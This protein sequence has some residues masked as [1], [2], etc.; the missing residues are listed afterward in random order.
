M[1]LSFLMLRLSGFR[2]GHS[3]ILFLVVIL[4]S[5]NRAECDKDSVRRNLLEAKPVFVI[6]VI[7][8]ERCVEA[9]HPHSE[10]AR[11]RAL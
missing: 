2:E 7:V 4:C 5:Y 1:E 6:E 11:Q 9:F 3:Y 10:C 8:P